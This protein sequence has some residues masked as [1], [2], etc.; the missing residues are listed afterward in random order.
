[1]HLTCTGMP[2]EKVDVALRVSH[3]SEVSISVMARKGCNARDTVYSVRELYM[4]RGLHPL[5]THLLQ[6]LLP[7]QLYSIANTYWRHRTTGPMQLGSSL[8][9]F[10]PPGH[11]SN[12]IGPQEAKLLGCRNVL[13][14]G[15]DAPVGK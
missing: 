6:Q 10:C 2:K 8:S 13:A 7:R 9:T 1:M 11:A 14:L 5:R 12:L 3:S 4:G 15:G